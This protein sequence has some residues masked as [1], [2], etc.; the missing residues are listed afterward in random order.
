M[1]SLKKPLIIA[2][3]ITT[4][5]G[6][7]FSVLAQKGGLK[8]PVISPKIALGEQFN[9]GDEAKEAGGLIKAKT[10]SFWDKF[11]EWVYSRQ[12]FVE[13]ELIKE[14][15]E[16]REDILIP[17]QNNSI[18]QLLLRAKDLFGKKDK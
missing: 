10:A 2:L 17:L 12:A 3:F 16:F 14:E 15:T 1:I 6:S 5:A 13:A 11:Q 7:A 9:V 8:D 18:Y 4:L